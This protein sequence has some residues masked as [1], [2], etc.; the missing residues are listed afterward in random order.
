MQTKDFDSPTAFQATVVFVAYLFFVFALGAMSA[1]ALVPVIQSFGGLPAQILA[2]KGPERFARRLLIIWAVILLPFMLRRCGWRG[3]SDTGFITPPGM[4]SRPVQWLLWGTLS[5]L[6]SL[7]ALS[8]INIWADN[9]HWSH[10]LHFAASVWRITGFA[11]SGIVVAFIEETFCRGVLFRVFS[12]CWG[13]LA[14]AVVTSLF[15]SIVHFVGPDDQAFA[16]G[17][18]FT[19]SV[20]TFKTFFTAIPQAS[21]FTLRFIN[22]TLLGLALCMFVVRTGT[23]WLSIGT[24]AGW[25]W[26]MKV[27]GYLTRW[28][29]SEEDFSLWLGTRS[30]M[31][32]SILGTIAILSVLLITWLW[33]PRKASV[34]N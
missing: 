13:M 21:H 10:H 30:D 26:I 28:S 31:T 6:V 17:S 20:N 19:M 15:F 27:N 14:A 25:V 18:W 7:G 32:D 9:R 1:A 22:L 23:I 8:L 4:P 16:T 3:W 33:R 34:L 11:L 29:R 2:D 5:G 12:R 24:H